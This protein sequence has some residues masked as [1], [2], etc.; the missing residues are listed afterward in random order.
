VNRSPAAGSG[1]LLIAEMIVA[2]LLIAATVAITW[3]FRRVVDPKAWSGMAMPPPW[4]RGPD[5][6]LGT[7]LGAAML[8]AIV[9]VE[10]AMG[11]IRFD[12]LKPGFTPT[13]I[14]IV[15]AARVLHF[16]ATAVC[17]EVAYRG[18]LLQNVAELFPVAIAA[19]VT[20]AVFALSHFPAIGFGF[21]FVASGLVG[22]FFLADMRVATR[23]IWLGVG[24][25]F[26]WDLAQ[27]VAG[28]VPGYSPFQTQ[29]LGPALWV[30]SGMSIEGGLLAMG[31]LTAGLLVRLAWARRQGRLA[32]WRT[33]LQSDG[34]PEPQL[35]EHD[36]GA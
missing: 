7:A 36:P 13:A 6:A 3:F 20:G 17:E 16:A 23:A 35:S 28:I 31:V 25:H 26:G 14:A 32:D 24:W 2:P 29:R 21:G 15:L 1:R 4:R 9:A 12:G 10:Y 8:A 34:T 27:D 11:W 19:L 5:L 33:K 22:S 18:Y 30:G